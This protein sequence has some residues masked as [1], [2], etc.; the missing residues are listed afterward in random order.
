M[1]RKLLFVMSAAALLML[2]ACEK[3]NPTPGPEPTPD[4][5]TSEITS[6]N[7][8]PGGFSDDGPSSWDN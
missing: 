3:P 4:P 1:K 7:V 5:E 8:A 6:N 2:A